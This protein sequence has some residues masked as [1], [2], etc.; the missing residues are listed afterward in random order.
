MGLLTKVEEILDIPMDLFHRRRGFHPIDLNRMV[1]RCMEQGSRKG[2]KRT[3]VPNNF[4]MNVTKK[5]ALKIA[6][7]WPSRNLYF[8]KW[9]TKTIPKE[10]DEDITLVIAPS[11]GGVGDREKKRFAKYPPGTVFYCWQIIFDHHEDHGDHTVDTWCGVWV[12]IDSGRIIRTW[13]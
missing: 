4:E 9:G 12:D 7:K 11:G 8:Y 10:N 6:K 3:Y 13:N 2:I 5:E 1:R